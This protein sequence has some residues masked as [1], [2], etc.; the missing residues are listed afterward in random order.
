MGGG[1]YLQSCKWGGHFW[2]PICGAISFWGAAIFWGGGPNVFLGV[3]PI[4]GRVPFLGGGGL[5]MDAI[6]LQGGRWQCGC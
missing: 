4:L 1:P 5:R 6:F 2:G 3:F